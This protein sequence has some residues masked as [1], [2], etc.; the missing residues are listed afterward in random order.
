MSTWRKFYWAWGGFVAVFVIAAML[1][2]AVPLAIP[3]IVLAAAPLLALLALYGAFGV[4]CPKCG[5]RLSQT[6]IAHGLPGEHCP[7]CMH[8]LK[9]QS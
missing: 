7:L 2:L 6:V 1:V 3:Q 9:E 8:D 4:S 5:V